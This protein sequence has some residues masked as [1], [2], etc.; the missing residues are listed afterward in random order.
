[1]APSY[2]PI[3]ELFYFNVR[4]GCGDANRSDSHNGLS[5]ERGKIVALLVPDDAKVKERLERF[6]LVLA[7]KCFDVARF[8]ARDLNRQARPIPYRRRA[9]SHRERR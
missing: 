4:E 8:D 3:T 7:Q 6:T 9:A 1:M 5:V 2:S